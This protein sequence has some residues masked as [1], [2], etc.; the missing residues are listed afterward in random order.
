MFHF[1]YLFRHVFVRVCAHMH[2]ESNSD[3]QA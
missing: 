1:I 3:H 2:M